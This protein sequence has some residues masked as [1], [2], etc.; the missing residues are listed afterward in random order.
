[1]DYK[2]KYL[3]YKKKY[4]DLKE[5]IGGSNQDNEN[6]QQ[7][8]QQEKQE[9]RAKRNL[10][11]YGMWH[12]LSCDFISEYMDT[13]GAEKNFVYTD[14]QLYQLIKEGG[15][16]EEY[17]YYVELNDEYDEKLNEEYNI[18]PRDE[19][20]II[21]CKEKLQL[22]FTFRYLYDKFTFDLDNSIWVSIYDGGFN[23]LYKKECS[24]GHVD[25]YYFE[26][27]AYGCELW[28][29]SLDST[30]YRD[31]NIEKINEK[32]SL[33]GYKIIGDDYER[34]DTILYRIGMLL[35][36]IY[37]KKKEDYSLSDI[38]LETTDKKIITDIILFILR[39]LIIS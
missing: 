38:Y 32:I 35:N 8:G 5:I 6:Q 11:E 22:A 39:K 16:Y 23:S 9:R 17:E 26:I 30:L 28:R 34:L 13:E 1:M 33:S 4:L 25:P 31:E 37:L 3:K 20:P 29:V 18:L 36:K 7:K 12:P 21:S 24:A 19:Y 10:I 14:R 15:L 27:N 2:Q